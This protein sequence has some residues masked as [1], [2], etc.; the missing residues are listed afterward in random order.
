[1]V[2][3]PRPT[4]PANLV[5]FTVFFCSFWTLQFKAFS[6]DQAVHFFASR[7]GILDLGSF[8]KKC[9]QNAFFSKSKGVGFKIQD[10]KKK[11]ESKGVGFK[12]QDPRFKA[13]KK[14]SWIQGFKI[15]DSKRE[16]LNPRG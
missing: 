11:L 13:Q 7:V 3:P 8:C 14:K 2:P 6:G 5:V 12:I 9:N 15:Q 16:F 4:F 1:M 10:S